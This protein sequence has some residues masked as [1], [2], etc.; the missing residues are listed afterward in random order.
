M[1]NVLDAKLAFRKGRIGDIASAIE[2]LIY[3]NADFLSLPEAVGVL[4]L[5]KAQLLENSMSE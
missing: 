3:S 2:E 1:S 5:V 4:E